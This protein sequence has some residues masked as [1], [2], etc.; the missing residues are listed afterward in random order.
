MKDLKRASLHNNRW[1]GNVS[2]RYSKS[3][4]IHTCFKHDFK[5]HPVEDPVQK[6]ETFNEC[7]TTS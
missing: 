6:F 1:H 3:E 7:G 5:L 2:K 4:D